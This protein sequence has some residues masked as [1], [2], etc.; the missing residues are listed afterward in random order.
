MIEVDRYFKSKESIDALEGDITNELLTY[1]SQC[2]DSTHNN[3]RQSTEDTEI[4]SNNCSQIKK[5]GFCREPPNL[6]YNTREKDLYNKAINLCPKTCGT[7]NTLDSRIQNALINSKYTNVLKFFKFTSNIKK[8]NIEELHTAFNNK[9]LDALFDYNNIRKF[10]QKKTKISND[11]LIDRNLNI[12]K[13]IIIKNAKNL[14]KYTK[15]ETIRMSE[16]NEDYNSLDL[17]SKNLY[18][19]YHNLS[20][21]TKVTGIDD[22]ISLLNDYESMRIKDILSDD[23]NDIKVPLKFYEKSLEDLIDDM[24]TFIIDLPVTFNEEY[25]N[26][27]TDN[28]FLK[29]AGSIVNTI[30]KKD[31]ILYIGLIGLLISILLYT[32]L[33]IE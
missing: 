24:L 12:I 6:P 14:V 22:H 16:L 19:K 7:C 15:N 21:S 4:E 20:K 28:I 1:N 27:N 2:I 26:M 25:K 8:E 5:R 18:D 30:F 13:R 9:N 31:N 11:K 29:I 33:I 10:I 3:I 23:V 17:K 32:I